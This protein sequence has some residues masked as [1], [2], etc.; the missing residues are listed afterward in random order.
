MKFKEKPVVIEAFQLTKDNRLN[1][2]V[3]PQWLL[4]AWNKERGTVG[5][6]Y[7][8]DSSIVLRKTATGVKTVV[9]D[10]LVP[11]DKTLKG[12]LPVTVD[13]PVIGA[14]SVI[15]DK[16]VTVD[17]PVIVD[18]PVITV[19]GTISLVTS[20]GEVVVAFGDWIIFG[21]DGE[22]YSCPSD[23]FIATY[24]PIRETAS[25]IA[26]AGAVRI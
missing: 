18:K 13:K 26:T 5:S 4:M 2:A 17:S 23:I 9:G 14:K 15:V 19:D 1:N 10:K 12:L 8:T 24:E 21:M 16:L 6:A 25:N 20:E 11:V 7:P 3:W 22:I